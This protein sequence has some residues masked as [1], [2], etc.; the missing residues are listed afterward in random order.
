[1]AFDFHTAAEI[2]S[3]LP[4]KR[5]IVNTVVHTQEACLFGEDIIVVKMEPWVEV[6]GPDGSVRLHR[7]EWQAIM[8]AASVMRRDE[9]A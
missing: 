4:T 9:V 5:E 3:P 2:M 6:S 1:M 8:R 7:A